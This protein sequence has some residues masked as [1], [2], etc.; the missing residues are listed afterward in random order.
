M[1]SGL[2][3]P[4]GSTPSKMSLGKENN[5]P[6]NAVNILAKEFEQRRQNFDNDAK[7]LAEIKPVQP[8]STDAELRNLKS[9]FETWKKDYKVRLRETKARLHKLGHGEIDRR[10]RRW[11]AKI[12]SKG[13]QRS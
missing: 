11:W 3:T 10:S 9:R 7:A 6:V 8:A 4:V 2:R 13:L 12:G 5:G 1:S